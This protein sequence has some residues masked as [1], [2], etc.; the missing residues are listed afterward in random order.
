[1]NK[2][3]VAEKPSVAL[4]LA[5]SLG[6]GKPIRKNINGVSYFELSSGSDRLYVVA[7]VGHL[8]TVAQKGR[9]SEL[10]IFDVEWVPSY[11]ASRFAY[12]TKKYLDVISVVGKKCEFFINACDYDIEGSVIGA[13]I[14]S[15]VLYSDSNR[16]IDSDAV[17]RM[18]FSTT[19]KADLSE[20]Y[21]N[22]EAFDRG[23]F[24]AGVTRHVLDWFWGIN[25]SRALMKALTK[26]GK[27]KTLSIG[28]VQGPALAILVKRDQEIKSFVPKDFYEVFITAK[29]AQF[30]NA[31]GQIFEEHQAK[32]LVEGAKAQ[33]KATVVLF[34]TQRVKSR[35]LPP[36]DLTSLQ[37]AA[38]AAHGIDPSRTL[39]I[40]QSLYERS[41][42]SYPRTSSQKLPKTLNLPRIIE[43]ISKQ[44]KYA[45][46]ARSLISAGRFLPAEGKKDDEAHPAIFPTGE[47]PKKLTQEEEKVYDLVVRRFLAAFAPYAELEEAKARLDVNGEFYDATGTKVVSYGW[48]LFYPFYKF[49]ESQLA[50]F[51][52]GEIVEISKA[53]AKKQK[54]KPPERYSKASLIALLE[55]KNLGTKATRAEIIDTLF[56]RGYVRGSRL[57]VTQLGYSVCSALAKYAPE[58]IDENLTRKLEADMDSVAHGTISKEE[59]INEGKDI[60]AHAIS[61]FEA[62]EKEVGEALLAGIIESEKASILGKCPNCGGDLSLRHSSSGKNYVRCSNWEK[63]QTSYPLP[64]NATIVATGKVCEICHTPI[65]KVFMRGKVFTM[66]LDPKCPTKESWGKENGAKG[67]KKSKG[68]ERHSKEA[69]RANSPT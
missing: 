8:F 2:L 28:R 33:G 35:P 24:E 29:G 59:V 26:A 53:E 60:I 19:T 45:E 69:E 37:V 32:E 67:R 56:R 54:T 14:I 38:S 6:D 3:I 63:C 13:N 10:P 48:L 20:A 41:Y 27:Y 47:Q 55:E 50:S 68:R 22:I 42:I 15:Y 4:R 64:A 11:K 7:A 39:A 36:F 16:E 31:R 40:A 23:N 51:R 1:M 61:K 52:E 5:L 49:K 43:S 9:S 65:V 34:E 66:D 18:R 17:M 12:Y 58:I 62:N 57:E 21:A 30:K 44:E 25:L 46:L